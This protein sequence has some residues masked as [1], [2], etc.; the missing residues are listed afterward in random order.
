MAH[1]FE[2]FFK[3]KK[4]NKIFKLRK[5]NKHWTLYLY[6]HIKH[7]F[8]STNK[9]KKITDKDLVKLLKESHFYLQ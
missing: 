2:P 9:I 3:E 4:K 1:L 7:P 6:P 8:K 5:K